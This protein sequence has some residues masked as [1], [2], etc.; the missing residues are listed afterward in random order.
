MYI[1]ADHQLPDLADQH[2]LIQ[3]HPLGAWVL[4][5]AEG[6]EANHIPFVLDP[7][8]GP[9]GT[10]VGHVARANGVWRALQPNRPSIVVFQGP[11]HYITP[12]WYPSKAEHG[13]VVPTWNYL[14]VHAHGTARVVDEPAALLALLHRL[15]DAQEGQRPAPWRVDDAPAPFIEGLMRAIVGIEI[16]ID[17][18]EGKRKA[19]QDETSPDHRGTVQG[20]L[21]EGS[22]AAQAMA[23][24]MS[25]P[26]ARTSAAGS[27][28]RPPLA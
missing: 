2:A 16:P 17:R 20:L 10:L 7:S 18:L 1:R 9:C 11:Q 8:R 5:T 14:A 13:Q 22:Q 27:G 26:Q 6:L 25:A 28:E 19:S 24:A 4:P 23:Q 21:G 15:T 3:A 12:S